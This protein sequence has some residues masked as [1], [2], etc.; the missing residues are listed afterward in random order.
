MYWNI[1]SIIARV[2]L[3]FNEVAWIP[4][5]NKSVAQNPNMHLIIIAT[6]YALYN[7]GYLRS[8]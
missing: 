4:R 8:K 1:W 7:G 3:I 5:R 6:Y 2:P